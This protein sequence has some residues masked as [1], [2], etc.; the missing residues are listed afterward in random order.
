MMTLKANPKLSGQL[1]PGGPML[2]WRDKAGGG[3]ERL[4]LTTDV[5]EN[6]KCT[7]RHRG[8]HALWVEGGVS[9]SLRRTT[10]TTK[11][12][13]GTHEVARPAFFV[14]LGLDGSAVEPQEG[15]RT[16]PVALA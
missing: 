8:I 16:D 11:S 15:H 10:I 1:T 6:P 14:S 7:K 9:A 12:R 13:P 5:C 2:L 4:L 3:R